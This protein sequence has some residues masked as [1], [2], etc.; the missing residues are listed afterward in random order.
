MFSPRMFTSFHYKPYS[1]EITILKHQYDKVI[2]MVHTIYIQGGI[3]DAGK[4]STILRLHD[5][6]CTGKA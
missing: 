1:Y 2:K 4:I 5:G 6:M 3:I